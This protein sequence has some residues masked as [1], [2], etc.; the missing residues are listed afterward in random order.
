MT[1]NSSKTL[2]PKPFTG[3]NNFE[4]YVTHLELLW[5]LQ[6]WQRKKTVNGAKTEI[7]ER[8]HYFALKLQNS[9]IDYY[10]TLS[11]DTRK[12]YDETVTFFS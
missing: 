8:L 6:H 4:S 11:E 10:H 3:S 2:L 9:D 5:Q 7:D 12:S 1:R